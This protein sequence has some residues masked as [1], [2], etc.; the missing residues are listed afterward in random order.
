MVAYGALPRGRQI[1]GEVWK[2]GERKGGGYGKVWEKRW[3]M[4]KYE[5]K[6]KWGG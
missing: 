4:E 2:I 6:G 3:G 1:M 5:R